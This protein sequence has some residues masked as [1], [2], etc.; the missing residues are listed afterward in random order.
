MTSVGEYLKKER[1]ARNLDLREVAE[2]TKISERY[3]SCIECGDYDKLPPGPYAKGYI[4]AYARQVCG[5]ETQA[6]A[7]Y[8]GSCEA[9]RQ[10]GGAIQT[11]LESPIS[12]K[13]CASEQD[14]GRS[15][16][17][18][19]LA[20][21][22]TLVSALRNALP[23]GGNLKH[24]SKQGAAKKSALT[25]QFKALLGTLAGRLKDLPKGMLL[26]GLL[27]T[28][29]LL[30]SAAVLVLAGFGAYHLFIFKGVAPQAPRGA[31]SLPIAPPP[32]AAAHQ[33]PATASAAARP[34]ADKDALLAVA[35]SPQAK[36][37]ESSRSPKKPAAEAPELAASQ[38]PQSAASK[39]S[40]KSTTDAVVQKKRAADLIPKPADPKVA[41]QKATPNRQVE[42]PDEAAPAMDQATELPLTLK[43]ASVCTA[44]EE[45]MPVGVGERFPWTTPKIFVWSLLRAS[46]PP[47]KVHHIYHHAGQVVS[48]VTLTVGSRHWRTWSFHTLSGQLHIGPWYVDITTEDGQ[49]MRRL[50][51]VIE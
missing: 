12:S 34:D 48:D 47:A 29:G 8:A 10:S 6:L 32:E 15:M 31:V 4:A 5:D 36:P 19:K 18:P 50:H 46:D 21:G 14:A 24:L 2:L 49:V 44:V 28:G 9:R 35:N 23:D 51:F 33:Q 20:G 1:Q 7:L 45:R 13:R 22:L 25:T 30:I 3:L 38:T 37:S 41:V 42:A 40:D 17:S 16:R 43:M 27:V 11:D 39:A 26:K